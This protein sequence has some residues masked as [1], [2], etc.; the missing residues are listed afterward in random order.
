MTTNLKDQ[1]QTQVNHWIKVIHDVMEDNEKAEGGKIHNSD[2]ILG[3]YKGR[4]YAAWQITDW[5][6]IEIDSNF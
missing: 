5:L 4:I 1:I 3:E 2:R 6:G